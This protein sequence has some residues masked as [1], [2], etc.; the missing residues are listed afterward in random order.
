[1]VVRDAALGVTPGVF[2]SRKMSPPGP[3]W[4]SV[5]NG[6][7]PAWLQQ[8]VWLA[9][10]QLLGSP[11]VFFVPRWRQLG[12]VGQASSLGRSKP[13]HP[14]GVRLTGLQP[15]GSPRVFF[16]PGNGARLATHGER[17]LWPRRH[18][19]AG[20]LL[21]C[22]HAPRHRAMHRFCA[23]ALIQCAYVGAPVKVSAR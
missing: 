16:V 8:M 10:R 18:T 3:R 23:H 5:F 22:P 4:A 20:T 11:S 1:M 9:G 7:G 13:G 12:H 21:P 14:R 19:V 15:P 17:L 6:Q 2:C